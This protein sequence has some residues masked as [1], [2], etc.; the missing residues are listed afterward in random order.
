MLIRA[1]RKANATYN[2]CFFTKFSDCTSFLDPKMFIYFYFYIFPFSLA[3]FLSKE[4]QKN[5]YAIPRTAVDTIFEK[6]IT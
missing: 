3:I 1:K 5:Y 2:C 4:N 6:S